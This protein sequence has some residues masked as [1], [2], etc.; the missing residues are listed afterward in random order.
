LI[1]AIEVLHVRCFD[2]VASV[3]Q[4][5]G[6]LK[7]RLLGEGLVPLDGA[8]GRYRLAAQCANQAHNQV[9]EWGHQPIRRSA[10]SIAVY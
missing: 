6:D 1:D 10:P 3:G 2:A 5:S 8:L 4:Q 9:R 7:D